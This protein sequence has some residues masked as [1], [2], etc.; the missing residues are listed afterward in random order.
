ML[1]CLCTNSKSESGLKS[2]P[3]TPP[4]TAFN[5]ALRTPSVITSQRKGLTAQPSQTGALPL[6][7]KRPCSQLPLADPCCLLWSWYLFHRLT[8]TELAQNVALPAT[9]VRHSCPH[10]AI[11]RTIGSF[12]TL[13]SHSN[14]VIRLS[15]LRCLLKPSEPRSD[16]PK[17]F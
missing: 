9:N 3:A 8:H 1:A 14:P 15:L 10:P 11:T 13:L 6:F 7:A 2:G 16:L 12:W 17:A 5:V 4:R